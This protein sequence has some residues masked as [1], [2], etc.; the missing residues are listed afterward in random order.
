LTIREGHALIAQALSNIQTVGFTRERNV[1]FTHSELI[2]AAA[3]YVLAADPILLDPTGEDA[4]GTWP[5][6]P[7]LFEPPEDALGCIVQ[8]AA[9]LQAEIDRLL[10]LRGASV[11]EIHGQR[12]G[13]DWLEQEAL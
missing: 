7:D 3:A 11:S 5:F 13:A 6:E 9:F 2:A 8:G 4:V 1:A 12:Q 10:A